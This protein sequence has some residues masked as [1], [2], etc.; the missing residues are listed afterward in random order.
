MKDPSVS[1]NQIEGQEN[2]FTMLWQFWRSKEFGSQKALNQEM[3]SH[4]KQVS[5]PHRQKIQGNKKTA[6]DFGC[7][8]Q[9]VQDKEESQEAI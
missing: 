9:R 5:K 4:H 1:L 2:F 6:G 7:R 3:G 8:N